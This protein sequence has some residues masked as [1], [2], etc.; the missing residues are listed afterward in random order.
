MGGL[1]RYY[2][3]PF[4]DAN[5]AFA[6]GKAAMKIEGTWW[7]AEGHTFFG[8]EAGNSNDW[9]WVPVPSSTGDAIFDLGIGST[10][11]IKRQDGAPTGNRSVLELLLLARDDGQ[12]SCRL[13]SCP[14]TGVDSSRKPPA[15]STAGMPR[16]SNR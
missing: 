4:A 11:S 8:K 15:V 5:A 10:Y 1:D 7:I 9:D 16:F 14:G 13:R 12:T 2:T 6:D 3:T